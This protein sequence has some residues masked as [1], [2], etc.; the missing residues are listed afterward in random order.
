MCSI[1]IFHFFS[2]IREQLK[3]DI[4]TVQI[5]NPKFTPGLAIVQ[6][7][8]NNLLLHFQVASQI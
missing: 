2:G 4:K 7:F 8:T 5:D 6:V 3:A 1:V